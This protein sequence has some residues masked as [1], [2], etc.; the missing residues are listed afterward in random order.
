[1]GNIY[2]RMNPI[3]DSMLVVFNKLKKT[4]FTVNKDIQFETS[5]KKLKEF[6]ELDDNEAAFFTYFFVTYIDY[7]QKPID[8]TILADQ[9]EINPLVFLSFTDEINSLTEK[10]LLIKDLSNIVTSDA[11]FYR[12]PKDVIRAVEKADKKMLKE[13]MKLKDDSLIYPDKIKEKELFYPKKIMEEINTLTDCLQKEKLEAIQNRLEE[14]ALPKGI[15]IM[16][17]GESGTGK[18]E[19]VF[20]IAKKTGRGIFYVDIPSVKSIYMSGTLKNLSDVFEKYN[21]IC[22]ELKSRGE[23]IPILLFN[24]ADSIFGKRLK[25]ASRGSEIDENQTQCVLLDLMEKQQGIIIATT[26]LSGNFDDAFERRFLFKMKFEKP[27]LEIKKKIWKNK[28]E[29]LD[30][31]TIERLA[32]N[33]ELSGAEIDNVVR[34]ATMQEVLSGNRSSDKE[35]ETYCQQERLTE[36]ICCRIGFAS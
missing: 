35:I 16:L 5:I 29:W 24:E 25:N 27:D 4:Y 23:E 10:G 13:S 30:S 26:N 31:K 18:T 22:I 6:F 32:S 20:Q 34:K 9:H 2:S 1:M 3:M 19:T 33:Y 14:K 8:I 11:K 7:H 12:V 21:K 17:H 15:C 28:M 36:K